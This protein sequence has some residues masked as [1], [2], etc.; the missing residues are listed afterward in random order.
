[1]ID[2]IVI[3]AGPAGL[4]AAMYLARFRRSVTVFDSGSPRAWRI[5]R[6]HNYPGMARGVSG[7]E[8]MAALREQVATY[9]VPHVAGRIDSLIRIPGG[10]EAAWAQSSIAARTVV[11]ATGVD[12]IEPAMPHLAEALRDGALRYCPVCDAF[13][14]IGKRVGVLIG[15]SSGID[16]A[17]CLRRYTDRVT[18]FRMDE[19]ASFTESD[20]Q[21]MAAAGI[22]P[23]RGAV[24]SVRA[25]QG[26]VSVEHADESSECDTLYAALGIRVHSALACALGADVD[27]KGYLI[28]DR[29]QQTS[30]SG[31]YAA[32]DVAS[33]LNQISVAYGGAAV[34]AAAINVAL[35]A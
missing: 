26:R 31:L 29:H 16:E 19:Q 24:K 14:V 5:P 15:N 33:G 6:S 28:V 2:T 27:E 11:L 17:V 20:R 1:M 3:G 18:V 4:L 34:A 13:E 23:A 10:F 12:D 35:S 21:R 32:G 7:A 30:V 22:V 8:L 9:D 25:W